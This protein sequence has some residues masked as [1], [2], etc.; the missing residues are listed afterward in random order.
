ME[1][2]ERPSKVA[3]R[4]DAVD[5]TSDIKESKGEEG[6]TLA[7]DARGEGASPISPAGLPTGDI[8]QPSESGQDEATVNQKEIADITQDPNVTAPPISKTKLKKLQRQQAYEEQREAR[9][10]IRK[11]KKAARKEKNRALQTGDIDVDAGPITSG[12]TGQQE[13]KNSTNKLRK[14]FHPTQF[15]IT[16]LIDC[17]FDDLM[18]DKE[19]IS[20]SSQLT[21][22]YAANRVAPYR[23]FVCI[24]S[25]T[26]PL[27]ERFVT[28]LGNC[29]R[30]WKNVRFEEED[31]VSASQ[32][33]TEKMRRM[34]YRLP[35]KGSLS[36]GAKV[37]EQEDKNEEKQKEEES[38][39]GEV[40][41]LTSDSPI[42]L[43]ELSPY[44]TYI[45]GGLVDRNRHKGICYQ[46]AMDRGVKTAKL[47]IGDYMRMASRF[48]LTTNQV[49]E[50]MLKWLEYGDWARAFAEV[51][52]KRKGGVLREEG[53][54]NTEETEGRVEITENGI[55]AAITAEDDEE[56]VEEF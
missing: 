46:R 33:A 19:R 21:R 12:D 14:Y 37:F 55:D 47:P 26:G 39:Q 40:I 51:I 53:D 38:R 56:G 10:L 20:L 52:P 50:I 31:F 49:L 25:F 23:A 29:Q 24:S 6:I 15:P 44:S 3:R 34:R 27:K 4:D 8:N 22:C 35:A 54:A 13:I 41:Y 11:E 18:T 28:V 1:E 32:S 2:E 9:K 45:I 36:G 30:G 5:V 43:T 7:K 16:F 48:V 42:T 17:S